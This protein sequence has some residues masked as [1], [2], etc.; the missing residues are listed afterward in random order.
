MRGS[1]N[2]LLTPIAVAS[3]IKLTA[4][5]GRSPTPTKQSAAKLS[6]WPTNIDASDHAK[7][8]DARFGKS[9]F[10][11][12]SAGPAKSPAVAPVATR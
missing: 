11:R 1:T 9:C 12:R 5:A 3:G 10:R 2:T 6:A 4:S 8:R 7:R